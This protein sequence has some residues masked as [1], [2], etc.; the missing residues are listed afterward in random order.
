MK[1]KAL[2]LI[3][4]ISVASLGLGGVALAAA[5]HDPN[6]VDCREGCEQDRERELCKE[7]QKQSQD[8]A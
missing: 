6:K 5:V 2:A 4:V 7:A 3:G 8:Q 1:T